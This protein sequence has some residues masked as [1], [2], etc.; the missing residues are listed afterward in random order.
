MAIPKMTVGDVENAMKEFD[1]N[2]RGLG[3]WAHWEDNKNHLFA[4]SHGG[5]LYPVKQIVSLASKAPRGDFGGG[6]APSDA[7]RSIKKLGF[8]IVPLRASKILNSE[9][10][11]GAKLKAQWLHEFKALGELAAETAYGLKSPQVTYKGWRI[12]SEHLRNFRSLVI[13]CP[14]SIILAEYP[15]SW[16]VCPRSDKKKNW[17]YRIQILPHEFRSLIQTIDTLSLV[18]NNEIQLIDRR[19]NEQVAKASADSREVRLTRL[20]NSKKVPDKV[21][22]YTSVFIRNPDVVAEV[23]FQANGICDRCKKAA[24]FQRAS[25]GSP[26]LEVHHNRRLADGGEDIVENAMALC[27]NCHR[28]SHYG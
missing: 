16:A 7:N 10:S 2:H 19:F 21:S 1:L 3:E 25:N 5:L 4:I 23:L 12:G 22:A 28:Q 27:P 24:P 26:Y 17:D 6:I 18:F 11:D 14:K 13:R 20:A 9:R 8:T 15:V